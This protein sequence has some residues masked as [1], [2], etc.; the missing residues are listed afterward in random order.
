MCYLVNHPLR[1]RHA[2]MQ[3]A[4]WHAPSDTNSSGSGSGSGSRSEKSIPVNSAQKR[5]LE[6][7]SEAAEAKKG[8]VC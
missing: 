3:D 1:V 7:R 5:N 6:L 8:I 4:L 2:L